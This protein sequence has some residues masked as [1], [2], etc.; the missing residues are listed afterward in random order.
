MSQ[1]LYDQ[2]EVP[3]PL[4]PLSLMKLLNQGPCEAL[5]HTAQGRNPQEA[6]LMGN[7]RFSSC[8]PGLLQALPGDL[9]QL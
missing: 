5:G 3:T 4:S 8:C 1:R 2:R 9:L 6:L 7:S